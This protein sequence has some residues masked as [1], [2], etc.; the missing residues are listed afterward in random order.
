MGLPGS[1][2]SKAL[3][4]SKN[5]LQLPFSSLD[6]FMVSRAREVMYRESTDTKASSA[7]IEVRTGR[8][9]RA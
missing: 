3:Y 7:G 5:K 2:S 8:K 6:E 1:I 4:E 9:W